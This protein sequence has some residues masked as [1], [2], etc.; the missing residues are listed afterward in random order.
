MVA[1]DRSNRARM[2]QRYK[3]AKERQLQRSIGGEETAIVRGDETAF[4]R[5]GDEN[6]I[7]GGESVKQ[8]A[9]MM[10]VM[11]MTVKVTTLRMIQIYLQTI[12]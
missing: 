9:S 7:V 10:T 3:S 2:L 5:G 1:N 4:V 6:A 12:T 11:T 8:A